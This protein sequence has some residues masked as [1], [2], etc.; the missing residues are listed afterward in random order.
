MK[1]LVSVLWLRVLL[2]MPGMF[3]GLVAVG[4]TFAWAYRKMLGCPKLMSCPR[5]TSESALSLLSLPAT[6]TNTLNIKGNTEK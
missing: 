2:E 6:K 4:R 3:S 1:F 5:G